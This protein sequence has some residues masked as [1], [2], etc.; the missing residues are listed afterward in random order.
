MQDREAVSG[1]DVRRIPTSRAEARSLVEERSQSL[2]DE[3]LQA[4]ALRGQLRSG[5]A[6]VGQVSRDYGDRFLLELI[7]NSY[8]AELP[9][10]AG[11][12]AIVLDLREGPYGVLYFANSGAPFDTED[13]RAICEMAQSSKRPGQGIGNKGVGFRSVL[14]VCE[15]PEVYSSSQRHSDDGFDGFCFSFAKPD[16]FVRLTRG[17]QDKAQV[18]QGLLSA[19]AL[20]VPIELQT[21]EVRHFAAQGFT[22]LVRL[23]LRNAVGRDRTLAQLEEVEGSP[24]VILFLDRIVR[25]DIQ[26]IGGDGPDTHLVRR[27]QSLER[28]GETRFEEVELK[29]EGRYLLASRRVDSARFSQAIEE[30]IEAQALDSE[31]REWTDEA[32][33]SVALRLDTD[34]DVGRLFSFLPMGP[35]ARAPLAAHLNAPFVVRLARD[36]LIPNAPLNELLLNEAADLCAGTALELREHHSAR[37]VVADLVTWKSPQ[38]IRIVSAF[39]RLSTR[40]EHVEVIPVLGQRHWSSLRD[41]YQW[42]DKGLRQMTSE[43][44]SRAA[45]VAIL[46]PAVGRPRAERI[47]ALHREIQGVSMKAPATVIAEWAEPVARDLLKAAGLPSNFNPE[48]WLQFYDDLAS[49]FGLAG[50]ELS[51][52]AILIDDTGKLRRC[53]QVAAP[54]AESK[55]PV[56]FF[57]SSAEEDPEEVDA[58]Q[59]VTIPRSLNRHLAY[60]HKALKWK[61]FNEQTRRYENRPGREFLERRRLVRL[62]RRHELL[63][64]VASVLT[65]TKS[66]TTFREALQFV[67][68]LYRGPRPYTQEPRLDQLNLRVPTKGGWILAEQA[69][70]GKAW[71][72][73][74]RGDQLERLIDDATS[75]SAEIGALRERLVL[76]PQDWPLKVAADG[77]V[78]F[79]RAIGVRDGLWPDELPV[80]DLRMDGRFWTPNEVGRRIGLE[81]TDLVHWSEGVAFGGGTPRHGWTE[82]RLT[83]RICRIAG[84]SD[85]EDLSPAAREVFARLI[86]VGLEVWPHEALWFSFSRPRTSGADQQSWPSPAWTFLRSAAWMPVTRPAEP[87]ATDFATPEEAWHFREEGDAPPLFVPLIVPDIRRRIEATS[88]LTDRLLGLGVRVWNDPGTAA[89]RIALL[90]ERFATGIAESQLASFRKAYE[91]AWSTVVSLDLPIPWKASGQLP[92]LVV[93]RRGQLTTL[94]LSSEE[95]SDAEPIYILGAEDRM[96]E[97]LLGSM[98]VP[99]LRVDPQDGRAVEALLRDV[100]V[101][102]IRLVRSGDFHIYVD[103]VRISEG[104]SGAFLVDADGG[105]LADLL[106]LTLELKSTQ[107]NR[108]TERTVREAVE[109]LRQI[110]L[111]AGSRLRVELDQREVELPA[112]LRQVLPISGGE[113]PLLVFEGDGALIDWSTLQRLTP[114]IAELV[115]Q[116]LSAPALEL[117]VIGLRGR[118]GVDG[119]LFIPTDED[120]CAV[121]GES[122]T[123]IREIRRSHHA[124]L[125]ELVYLLRPVIHYYLGTEAEQRFAA[126]SRDTT[127]EEALESLLLVDEPG[128]PPG[129]T[130]EKLV[131][132]ARSSQGLAELR[133]ALDIPYGD[134]NRS[135][136]SV[137]L[138]YQPFRNEEDHKST[139]I[140]FL[141]ANREAILGSLREFYVAEFDAGQS[142]IRY[143]AAREEFRRASLGLR[144]RPGE[145]VAHLTPD[146]TWLDEVE[147][148]SDDQLRTCVNAWL[149]DIGASPLDGSRLKLP[150][151]AE[152]QGPNQQLAAAI[153]QEAARIIP[154]WCSKREVKCPAVWNSVDS[155]A[156][157][158]QDLVDQGV[159]DFRKLKK[160]DVL[161]WLHREGTWPPSMPL[162]TGLTELGLTDEDLQARKTVVELE[163]WH[164]ELIR[165][166][167]E[168]DGKRFSLEPNAA[169]ELIQAVDTHMSSTLLETAPHLTTLATLHAKRKHASRPGGGS[170]GVAERLSDPQRNVI[171]FVGELVAFRWLQKHY[172]ATPEAWHSTNRRF[173]FPD[174]EGNDALGYDFKV[175]QRRGLPMMFEVKATT[176]G[177]RF[178]IDLTEA[179]IRVAQ[180]NARNKRYRILYITNVL[181]SALRELYV[182]PNPLAPSSRDFYRV[183]GTGIRYEF[184]LAH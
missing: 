112:S 116:S 9:G 26:V 78:N 49:L 133:D 140:A 182:L 151:L 51:A 65:R 103:E 59:G 138:P 95:G 149:G 178:A 7:Q 146:D 93:S 41:S 16:D 77:W 153:I 183:S 34:Q 163:R 145:D 100:H 12:I 164:R 156:T 105:W 5:K 87:G 68:R 179:E 135:L 19:Y 115:G 120:Y 166:S 50:V 79:L 165:R 167:V 66:E 73:S 125:D 52:K 76:A 55:G 35:D 106:A 63:G 96:A 3:A 83:G 134:F 62:P 71:G 113:A 80:R 36:N 61:V 157:I 67:Y 129:I 184:E 13:V 33:V 175:P 43:R 32:W 24:P 37:H 14:Q 99:L 142:T 23:P 101:G 48:T 92:P 21:E 6:F 98:D 38:H 4:R 159:L 168:L 144:M 75:V 139:F 46:D 172:D 152:V 86:T 130:A 128:M 15:W 180:E 123:R 39:E 141:Q 104:A 162:T 161:R 85:Y 2:A 181:D 30:S 47:E 74:T 57:H 8:D 160:A 137:G 89:E 22:T 53:W 132:M 90:G 11:R 58:P 148:P 124:V 29:P 143:R 122:V 154:I 72:P 54:D 25:I 169:G 44:I 91:R 127:S 109:H 147:L 10:A 1:S 94:Q 150:P 20:P 31:W 18:L 119:G 121:F 155:E 111:K 84:Q 158:L 102:G 60:T 110:R 107:F 126:R 28:N 108:Q 81:G 170:G 136:R 69:R 174:Y 64:H 176:S 56:V 45:S 42:E 114:G 17:D 70:F 171:G 88:Q 97:A 177:S 118:G 27:S 40:I 82:Y 117:A 131:E 173:L